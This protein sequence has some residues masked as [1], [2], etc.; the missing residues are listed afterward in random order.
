MTNS[1]QV[2]MLLLSREVEKHL[3]D[4]RHLL[5][6]ILLTSLKKLS[7]AYS[8]PK[9]FIGENL[10]H[11]LIINFDLLLVTNGRLFVLKFNFSMH[12]INTV[13]NYIV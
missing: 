4:E 3:F 10:K 2:R 9:I 13:C 5:P 6:V 12:E 8:F 1:L 11:A 7:L